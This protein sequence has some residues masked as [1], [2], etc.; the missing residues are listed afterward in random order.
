[1][2]AFSFQTDD[3][4]SRL[5]EVTAWC[6]E[7]YFQYSSIDAI[8]AINKYYDLR[9]H[10]DDFYHHEGAYWIALRVHYAMQ[11][12]GD[13]NWFDQWRIDHGY[14]STPSEA[15]AYFQQHYFR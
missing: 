10:D 8:E 9:F 4:T 12:N 6:L 1:M 14:T 2:T 13:R 3:D 11:V 7:K 15:L 5:L